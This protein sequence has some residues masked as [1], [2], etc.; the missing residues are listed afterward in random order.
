MTTTPTLI[1]KDAARRGGLN[2]LA[3]PSLGWRLGL[4]EASWPGRP[5][6]PNSCCTGGEIRRAKGRLQVT[7]QNPDGTWS[8][9]IL[10][11]YGESK[12][13]V[14]RTPSFLLTEPGPEGSLWATSL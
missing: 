11:V 8:H 7:G 1:S 3:L 10:L 14:P 5:F 12:E 6:N 2:H 13:A 9:N 4:S